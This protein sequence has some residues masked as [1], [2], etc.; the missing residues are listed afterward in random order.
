MPLKSSYPSNFFRSKEEDNEPD[1][2]LCGSSLSF[3]YSKASCFDL[4]LGILVKVQFGPSTFDI[5][6]LY[7]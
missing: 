2:V 3:Y 5:F 7:I 4:E 1:D 6:N